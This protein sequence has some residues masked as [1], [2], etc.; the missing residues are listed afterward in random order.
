MIEWPVLGTSWSIVP[1]LFTSETPSDLR[2]ETKASTGVPEAEGLSDGPAVAVALAEALGDDV[3][4]GLALG[5]GLATVLPP[6]LR[7]K[8]K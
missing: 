2:P 5:V 7:M 6:V 8:R 4:V 3:I 1:S